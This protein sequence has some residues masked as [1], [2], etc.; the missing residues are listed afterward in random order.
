MGNPV[1]SS[2]TRFLN[3][4]YMYSRLSVALSV[5]AAAYSGAE[6]EEARYLWTGYGRVYGADV[7]FSLFVLFGMYR[8]FRNAR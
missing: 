8:A 4:S 6:E 7:Q 3:H 2:A 5:A 1:P